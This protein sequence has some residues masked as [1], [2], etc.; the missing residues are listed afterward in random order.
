VDT[1]D[2]PDH[3]DN[4]DISYA[5]DKTNNMPLFVEQSNPEKRDINQAAI[6]SDAPNAINWSSITA[7]TP[8][9]IDTTGYQTIIIQKTTAGIITP[10]ISNDGAT[11]FGTLGALSTTPYAPASTMPAATG[12][13]IFPVTARYFRLTG[14]ASQVQCVIYLR[15]T[16]YVQ[17]IN[18]N[19]TAIAGT[20]VVTG[21]LAGT[22]GIGSSVA[23]GVAPTSNPVQIGGVDA[24]R[25]NTPG[26]VA[27][28]LTPKTRRALIDE[29]G[30]F[31]N[32]PVD[33]NT[34]LGF[35]NN[36][37]QYVKDV[38][39]HEGQSVIELLNHILVE[40]RSLNYQI[41]ELPIS[42]GAGTMNMIDDLSDIRTEMKQYDYDD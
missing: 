36:V 42:I 16:P 17:Y 23:T 30:R 9:T 27:A 1:S 20:A 2:L 11:W 8:I 10:T 25:L 15:Q 38:S 24:G 5:M 21:G 14:P 40:L 18:D 31:I 29:A 39:Q 33:L 4:L 26:A 37:A 28:N 19:L 22:L 32:A 3:L 12:I 6:P 41:H 7:A 34:G 35:Q 13:Y